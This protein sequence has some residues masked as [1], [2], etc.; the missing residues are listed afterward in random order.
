MM[1][2]DGLHEPEQRAQH[3]I[4]SENVIHGHLQKQFNRL[5]FIV[6]RVGAVMQLG[7][8]YDRPAV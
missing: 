6:I 1:A 8:V 5:P 2:D 4:H 7:K 3:Q